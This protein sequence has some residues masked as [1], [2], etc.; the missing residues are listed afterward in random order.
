[1]SSSQN[2]RAKLL[3]LMKILHE[4]S[5]E[6]NPITMNTIIA[7]LAGYD[8]HAERKSIYNDLEVLRN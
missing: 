8:V 6:Q 2:Q 3:L 5:D 7:R 4:K 1:M